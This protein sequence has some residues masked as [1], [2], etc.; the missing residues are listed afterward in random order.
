MLARG[1]KR[2]G[3]STLWGEL[4]PLCFVSDSDFQQ[5]YLADRSVI[6]VTI[7]TVLFL[8]GVYYFT[9]INKVFH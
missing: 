1:F 9:I 4:F 7:N 6:K 2:T 8:W 3:H 5:S